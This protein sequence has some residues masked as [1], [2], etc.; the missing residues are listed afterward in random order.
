MTAKL[1]ALNDM[2]AERGQKLSQMAVAW[3]LH[4]KAVATVLVGASRPEQIEDNVRAVENLS[5][6]DEEL[7]RIEKIL[8]KEN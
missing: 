3:L 2:A 6:S 1:N 5:F 8:G 7:E 4:N